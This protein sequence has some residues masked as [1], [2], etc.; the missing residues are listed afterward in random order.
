VENK[1]RVL[2]IFKRDVAIFIC[3]LAINVIVA[4]KFGPN[5]LSVWMILSL[6]LSY[7][8]SIFRTKCDFASV[9]LLSSGKH[10]KEDIFL[11]LSFIT[12]I[13][14]IIF[15]IFF[16]FSFDFIYKFFFKGLNDDFKIELYSISV[17]F[18]FSMIHT[19][20]IYFFQGIK[21]IT[22][23]N[24]IQIVQPLSFIIFFGS[25]YLVKLFPPIWILISSL[26][27]SYLIAILFSF[28]SYRKI[29]HHFGSF[30][31]RLIRHLLKNSSGF[32][33]AGI[34][35]QIYEHGIK[36]IFINSYTAYNFM[37]FNQAQGLC[38]LILKV[39]DA[40]NVILYPHLSNLEKDHRFESISSAFRLAFIVLFFICFLSALIIKEIIL[41][42]YGSAYISTVTYFYILLPAVFFASLCSFLQTDFN[43]SEKSYKVPIY[44]A[45]P[46][47]FSLLFLSFFVDFLDFNQIVISYS[48]LNVLSSFYFIYKYFYFHQY[49]FLSFIPTKNDFTILFNYFYNRFLNFR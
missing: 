26:L 17:I 2:L 46:L 6:I 14:F 23:Y 1:N 27:F 15:S 8:E 49:N 13:A 40:I 18:L 12:F 19:N 20:F 32:Y 24:N 33:I 48:I 41:I 5:V 43:A 16:I 38:R 30:N 39:P 22:L 4:R 31:L 9:Q 42:F 37:Y 3:N 21:N 10:T 44:Q 29:V 47:I 45:P 34:F 28:F 35:S 25:F 11:N 36:L 7:F